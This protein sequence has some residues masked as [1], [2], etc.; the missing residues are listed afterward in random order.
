MIIDY[1]R[2]DQRMCFEMRVSFANNFLGAINYILCLMRRGDVVVPVT[3]HRKFYNII[4][5]QWKLLQHSL[6]LWSFEIYVYE[7]L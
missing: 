6:L 5:L 3:A 1:G 7:I 4:I 2:H